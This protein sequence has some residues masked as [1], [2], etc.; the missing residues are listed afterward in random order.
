MD[1][2]HRE[3]KPLARFCGCVYLQKLTKPWCLGKELSCLSPVSS[4]SHTSASVL[5]SALCPTDPL[6]SGQ[7][8]QF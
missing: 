6:L 1:Q 5:L 8:T 7:V 2:Q 4:R 3:I